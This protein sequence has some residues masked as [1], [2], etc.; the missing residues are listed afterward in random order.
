[1]AKTFTIKNLFLKKK[2]PVVEF[3]F[4]FS[5]R[6]PESLLALEFSIINSPPRT[7]MDGPDF[8]FVISFVSDFWHLTSDAGLQIFKKLS[9]WYPSGH[10]IS[11]PLNPL[12]TKYFEQSSGWATNS[13]SFFEQ[14][15]VW[16]ACGSLHDFWMGTRKEKKKH[17]S[18]KI[19]PEWSK[20]GPVLRYSLG[21]F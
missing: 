6:S 13:F 3:S 1:M 11:K 4:D 10:C 20:I 19:L 9:K 12:Q 7:T 16:S 18:Y 2:L 8:S 17:C 15:F 5:S 21:Y 14:N